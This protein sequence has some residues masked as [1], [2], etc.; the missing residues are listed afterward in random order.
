MFRSIVRL[1]APAVALTAASA[2]IPAMGA[3]EAQRAPIATTSGDVQG[4]PADS[5]GVASFKGI[6]YAAPPVGPLRWRAPQPVPRRAEALSATAFGNSCV[7]TPTPPGMPQFVRPPPTPQGEDCLTL[8]VW[9]AALPVRSGDAPKPVMVWIYGGGFQFGSSAEPRY[10]GSTLAAQGVVVVS[11]NYRVG[12]LG[13]LATPQLDG[14]SGASGMWGLLDQIAALQWVRQ[15]IAKFGGDPSR[16]TVFG[17]SAGAHAVGLLLASP[18]ARGLVHGA[19]LQSGAFW[20]TQHGSITTH[21]EQ[22]SKGADFVASFPPGT[23][24]RSV[25]AAT[26]AQHAPWDYAHDPTVK[27]PGGSLAFGPSLDGDGRVGPGSLTPSRS[28]IRT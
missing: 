20:E 25:D 5:N 12:A 24:L 28:Q 15:N 11:M 19:I 13:F 26:V 14:E 18:K 1:V 22:L 8:N 9:T 3:A 23:D 10:D 2:T 21:E 6:P 7:A 27:V 16:V 17:E 4:S